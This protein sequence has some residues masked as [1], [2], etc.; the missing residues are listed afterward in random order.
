MLILAKGYEIM[1]EV[2]YHAFI[3]FVDE[4]DFIAQLG[5]EVT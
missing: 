1:A 4:V 2:D 3:Y 5:A